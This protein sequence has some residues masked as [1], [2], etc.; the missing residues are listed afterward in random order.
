MNGNIDAASI[1]N[2]TIKIK[3]NR[4]IQKENINQFISIEPIE[5]F[6]TSF[7]QN[8]LNIVFVNNLLS[9]TSY[10]FKISKELKD[11]YGNSLENDFEV[12][13]KTKELG[14]AYISND[15]NKTKDQIIRNSVSLNSPQVLF[16]SERIESFEINE[17][18]LVAEIY[19]FDSTENIVIKNLE[20]REET[21]LGFNNRQILGIDISHD[22]KLLFVAQDGSLQQNYFVPSNSASIYIYDLEN[23]TLNLFLGGSLSKDIV[24]AKFTPLGNEVIYKLSDTFFYIS[25]I[26]DPNSSVVLGRYTSLGDFNNSVTKILFTQINFLENSTQLPLISVFTRDQENINITSGDSFVIDPIYYNRSDDILY[27]ERIRLLAGSSGIFGVFSINENGEKKE[28]LIN[29]EYS[30]ELPSLSPDDRF[31]AVEKYSQL[32]LLDF[33]DQRRSFSK[34]KPRGGDIEIAEGENKNIILNA[35]NV[36]WI[37]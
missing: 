26:N 36:R 17:K 23:K 3:F 37:E 35:Y 29:N 11:I 7:T 28:I 20:T 12:N 30:L 1:T 8:D 22:N 32:N 9:N 24:E 16:E 4:P 19:K 21:D 13:F 31:L 18:F 14:I 27:S 15:P 33:K 25:P 10:K 2:Q 6:N 5:K 34:N